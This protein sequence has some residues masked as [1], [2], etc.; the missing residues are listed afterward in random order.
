MK[1]R[2]TLLLTL[3]MLCAL[4]T[5]VW[6]NPAM[7]VTG[8]TEL[9]TLVKPAE[10]TVTWSLLIPA[11]ITIANFGETNLGTVCIS[12]VVIEGGVIE[13]AEIIA[14]VSQITP[15]VC[16]D[17]I[18]PFT[19]KAV[20]R[21]FNP[22]DVREGTQIAWYFLDP[23]VSNNLQYE[24]EV[25]LNLKEEDFLNAPSGTYTAVIIYTSHLEMW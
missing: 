5:S 11:D 17:N 4:N 20:M 15:F 13:E 3:V 23:R 22:I 19:L 8:G 21:D 12:N 25:I 9:L 18:I 7:A 6:M 1:K 24:T 14:E 16:G 10:G 2:F